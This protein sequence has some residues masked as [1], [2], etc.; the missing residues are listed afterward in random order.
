MFEEGTYALPM[1][2][3]VCDGQIATLKL[4]NCYICGRESSPLALCS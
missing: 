3:A 1:L 2:E 4:S